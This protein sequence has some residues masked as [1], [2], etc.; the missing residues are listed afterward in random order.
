MYKAKGKFVAEKLP[1]RV[2]KQSIEM[3]FASFGSGICGGQRQL[4][5]GV[6]SARMAAEREKNIEAVDEKNQY[7]QQL[8]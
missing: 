3:G 6:D 5:V 1:I 2:R 4:S 7:H 8:Q